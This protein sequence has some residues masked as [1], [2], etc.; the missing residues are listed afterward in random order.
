VGS[1][2]TGLVDINN[3]PQDLV[4][5][6]DVVTG[7]ASAAYGSD[8]LAGVV[9]FV[10]DKTYEGVKGEISGGMT[11]YGDDYN[12]R[13]RLTT[14]LGFGGDRGHFIFSGELTDDNGIK[15]VPRAWNNQGIAG[16]SYITGAPRAG[17]TSAV[18][19]PATISR[20][21]KASR[22]GRAI[23]ALR[24]KRTFAYPHTYLAGSVP[25]R[26]FRS[27]RQVCG[28]LSMLVAGLIVSQTQYSAMR[29]A[30]TYGIA[31]NRPHRT[32]IRSSDCWRSAVGC[33]RSV[34]PRSHL[35]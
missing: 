11:S 14:G 4:S 34:F 21:I 6:V 2:A 12:Y 8:A 31:E 19:P 18:P 33:L 32:E 26:A 24:H 10:L 30:V 17:P 1:T 25:E 3:I 35:G 20:F 15:G 5:R 16:T 28:G 13:V 23:S 9:N 7:G 22:N 29:D 27:R